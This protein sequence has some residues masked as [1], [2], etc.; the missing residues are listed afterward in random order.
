MKRIFITGMS[1]TG[2]SSV[3]EALLA[4]EFAAID[5]DYDDWCELSFLNGQSEWIWREDRMQ[6]LLVTPRE[7]ALFVSGCRS[8]QAKF[9]RFFDY[10]ILLSAPLEVMLQRVAKRSS[11]PYGKSEQ[12]RAEIYLNF[13]YVQPLLRKSADFELD[14]TTM[15]VNEVA[16]FL[17]R[18]TSSSLQDD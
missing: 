12:E 4:R 16:D 2:K 18:L 17:A 7:S 6:N 10:K 9:Y 8:N 14:T 5:T 11:N 13:E 15:S 3:M 1:G